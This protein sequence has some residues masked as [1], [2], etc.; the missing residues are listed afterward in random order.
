M[1]GKENA[2]WRA[3]QINDGKHDQNSFHTR[4]RIRPSGCSSLLAQINATVNRQMARERFSAR[5]ASRSAYQP[6]AFGE[7]A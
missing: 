1:E 4:T 5:T 3:Q 2:R 7:Q 6:P